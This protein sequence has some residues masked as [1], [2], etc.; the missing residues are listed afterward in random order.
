MRIRFYNNDQTYYTRCAR[1]F[2]VQHGLGVND[3]HYYIA[4]SYNKKRLSSWRR[5]TLTRLKK[6]F[7]EI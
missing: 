5:V 3:H 4:L 1:E 7:K 6:L 2:I